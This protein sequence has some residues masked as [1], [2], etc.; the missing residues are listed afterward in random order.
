VAFPRCAQS[1]HG[2]VSK[3]KP[4]SFS[5]AAVEAEDGELLRSKIFCRRPTLVRKHSTFAACCWTSW[6]LA[7]DELPLSNAKSLSLTKSKAAVLWICLPKA[8]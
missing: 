1:H 7:L 6:K 3:E 5:D 4:E 2:P 8:A